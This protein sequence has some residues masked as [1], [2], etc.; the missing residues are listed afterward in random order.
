MAKNLLKNPQWGRAIS[1]E[2]ISLKKLLDFWELTENGGSQWKV[3]EMPG[4]CGSDWGLDGVTKYFATSFE[5]CLKRQVI[6]LLAEDYSSEQLDAQP[7]V[8]VEE[9][10]RKSRGDA[11]HTPSVSV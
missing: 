11:L 8:T 10:V 1:I 4:D 2:S 9:L 7:P 3:E 5:L 6:D